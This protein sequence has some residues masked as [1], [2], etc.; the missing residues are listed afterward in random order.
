[1]RRGDA[2]SVAGVRY[3]VAVTSARSDDVLASDIVESSVDYGAR[4]VKMG[5]K[6]PFPAHLRTALSRDP[7]E[8]PAAR[9]GQYRP[10]H[11]RRFRPGHRLHSNSATRPQGG[12]TL[13]P[14]N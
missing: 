4:D 7:T 5:R 6:T 13:R 12:R 2:N 8:S 9:R 11:R 3:D 14:P 10:Q 1:M